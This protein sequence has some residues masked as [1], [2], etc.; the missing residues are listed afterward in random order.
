MDAGESQFEWENEYLNDL[1]VSS[2]SRKI[3][4]IPQISYSLKALSFFVAYDI[5]IYQY[6]NGWQ[7][8]SEQQLT[9]GLNYR[10]LT[11]QREISK[12]N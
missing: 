6:I 10:F 11:K 9:I 1:E 4:I 3:F 8:G 5:P 12:K 2:G 7:I